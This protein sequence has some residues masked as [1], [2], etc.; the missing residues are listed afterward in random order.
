MVVKTMYT[1]RSSAL[2]H[3]KQKDTGSAF[4]DMCSNE[5]IDPV[6]LMKQVV[7]LR[8]QNEFHEF[9]AEKL[10][11]EIQNNCNP[12]YQMVGL[13]Y[14]RRGSIDINPVRWTPGQMPI[15]D[16][17]RNL[18]NVEKLTAKAFGQ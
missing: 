2:K 5:H 8:E 12:E 11:V 17:F 18:V 15:D 10:F 1:K 3:T 16:Y 14:S 6:S 9:C 13:L 7:S 4:F